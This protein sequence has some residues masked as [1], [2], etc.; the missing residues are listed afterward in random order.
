[1][2]GFHINLFSSACWL[3]HHVDGIDGL[4]R[5]VELIKQVNTRVTNID[6]SSYLNRTIEMKLD[7]MDE[8]RKS[9]QE[10]D[11]CI[12]DEALKLDD[13]V[14]CLRAYGFKLPNDVKEKM[15]EFGLSSEG[16]I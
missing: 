9:I 11:R 12:R 5:M 14:S 4:K 3:H 8:A 15:V 10:A 1:M 7:Y 16:E 13:Y 2:L 6:P